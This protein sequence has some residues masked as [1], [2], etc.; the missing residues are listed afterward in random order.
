MCSGCVLEGHTCLQRNA[1]RRAL[2]TSL[3]DLL[4]T[5]CMFSSN[6]LAT[7]KGLCISDKCLT[8][9]LRTARNL[10]FVNA[11]SLV[12]FESYIENDLIKRI[13]KGQHIFIIN[14][15]TAQNMEASNACCISKK[16]K[17]FCYINYL[18]VYAKLVWFHCR[19][20]GNIIIDRV[21]N[22][23]TCLIA[24]EYRNN[25][26]VGVGKRVYL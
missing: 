12:K 24:S 22:I 26:E 7:N 13:I 2:Q 17:N 16:K 10:L 9:Q 19:C 1:R 15:F 18:F 3:V 21:S 11:A 5:E 6:V 25:C 23:N 4:V 14:V 20:L 8:Q